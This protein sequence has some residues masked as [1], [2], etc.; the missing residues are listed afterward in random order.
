MDAMLDRILGQLTIM[1]N[2]LNSHASR[3]AR[4]ETD[5]P[6]AGKGAGR[7]DSIG[8]EDEVNDEFERRGTDRDPFDWR[9]REFDSRGGRDYDD[10]GRGYVDWRGRD[11]YERGYDDRADHGFSRTGRD[12]GRGF[13][14]NGR[15]YDDGGGRSFDRH[16]EPHRPPKI[17]FPTYDGES[18]PLTWLNKCENFFRGHRVPADEKV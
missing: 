16:H 12:F 14:D 6:D 1:N 3:L 7:E 17:P 13:R 10:R 4:V 8:A 11:I 9:G 15:D 18:D 2:R 5:K